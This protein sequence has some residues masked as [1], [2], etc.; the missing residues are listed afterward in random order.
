MHVHYYST[1][2]SVLCLQNIEFSFMFGEDLHSLFVLL[3]FHFQKP[4]GFAVTG[5][6]GSQ[7]HMPL[8][9]SKALDARRGGQA[10][11]GS[12]RWRHVAFRSRGGL[13]KCLLSYR[14]DSNYSK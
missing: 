8:L 10:A 6:R 14:K 4:N 3:L 13:V 1:I 2:V 7:L 9:T 11:V 12:P 5:H